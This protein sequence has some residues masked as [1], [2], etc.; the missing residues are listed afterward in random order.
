[1]SSGHGIRAIA[2]VL[3][4]TLWCVDLDATPFD[5]QRCRADLQAQEWERAQRFVFERDRQRYLRAR[6]A[7]RCLRAQA[8]GITPA[9]L[10]LSANGH[11]KPQ[12][13][14]HP[15]LAFNASHSQGWGLIGMREAASAMEIGVD[16]EIGPA[17]EDANALAQTVFDP[18][19]ASALRAIQGTA[20]HAAAFW[21]GWTR[22]EAA[23]KAIGTGFGREDVALL[24]GLDDGPAHTHA[25]LGAQ[26]WQIQIDSRTEP[27]VGPIAVAVALALASPTRAQGL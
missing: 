1:V 21:R 20:Q 26:R 5:V 9:A 17:P 7:L 25:V 12:L 15:Q 8:L 18:S 4:V 11:G 2:P 14:S 13:A 24:S 27:G 23:L 22:R 6:H 16:I 19:E 3:G 10:Q